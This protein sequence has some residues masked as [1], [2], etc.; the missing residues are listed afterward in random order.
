MLGTQHVRSDLL[1]GEIKVWWDGS[2]GY[3]TSQGVRRRESQAQADGSGFVPG[4]SSLQGGHWFK[5]LTPNQKRDYVEQLQAQGLSQ[6]QACKAVQL[7]RSVLSY[8]SQRSSDDDV[9]AVLQELAERFPERGFGKYYQLIR[10]RGHEWNHK[11]VYR[12]YC[13]LKMNRR[14]IGKKRLPSRD[15][16]PLAVPAE[17]NQSG[18]MDFMSDALWCGRR[19]RTFNVMDDFNREVLAIEIDLN[20]PASRVIRVLE[21]IVAWRGLPVQ[22]RMD[23]GPEFISASFAD[24]AQKHG[25]HL[26]FIKPGKPMQNGFVARFNRSYRQG[27]LD[28]YVFKNLKEVKEKTEIWMRDYNE[29]CPHDS[30]DGMTPV[31]YRLFHQAQNSSN[32]WH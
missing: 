31:E 9:I 24:W 19:F 14:R 10:R 7:S 6:R 25:V 1:P 11:R 15:P 3:Q 12:V 18:S 16:P 20:L 5:G 28:R 27:V 32:T 22:I 17:M 29:Q 26:E 23:N 13:E 21:R 30:L 4:E 8:T 2:S